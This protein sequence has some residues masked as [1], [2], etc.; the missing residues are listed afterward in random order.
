[1]RIIKI[2]SEEKKDLLLPYP[3]FIDKEGMVGR[4]D[5][6]KGKPEKLI[7]FQKANEI[8][9]DL[10]FGEFWKCP[11]KAVGLYPVFL[12]KNGRWNTYFGSKIGKVAVKNKAK[13]ETPKEAK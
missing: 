5:F 8:N 4:Q 13:K 10:S 12:H 7:G 9:I 6:W 3:F 11:K 2:Q 1:M